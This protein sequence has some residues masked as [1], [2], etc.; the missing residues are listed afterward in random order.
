M[1]GP[2]T[3]FEAFYNAEFWPGINL[4]ADLQCINSA[5]GKGPLVTET[6]DNA[7]VGG[8]RLRIEL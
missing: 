6:P 4:T 1:E 2:A 5:F 3:G 7:W 8:L